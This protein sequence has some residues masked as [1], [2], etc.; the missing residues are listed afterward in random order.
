MS[1]CDDDRS[2]N[3][4]ANPHFQN[5]LQGYLT[6]RRVLQ[7]GLA[8]VTLSFL[9]LP[10]GGCGGDSD[11]DDDDDAVS[12]LGFQSISAS[13]DDTVRVPEGY[14]Y[15]V[16]APWGEPIGHISQAA[17]EP[18]YKDDASNTA[19]EQALQVG[20]HHDGMH[21]F[22][23]PA[24][25]D[26]SDHGLLVMNH[27]YVDDGLLQ[28]GGIDV[29]DAGFV[30]P[31]GW[32]AEKVAKAQNGHG[33]TILEIRR[34]GQQW[35]IVAPSQYARRITANTPIDI[36][37]PA[38]GSELMKTESDPAGTRVLGT[39]N[40]CAHGYTPWNTYLTCEENWNGY[41]ANPTGDVVGV[42]DGDQKLNILS[43]QSRYGI[44]QTGFGYRWH[45]FDERFDASRHPNEP[46]RF[47]W[48][49]EIDPFDP[50]STPVKHTAMGRIKHENA[51]YLVA[52]DNR[53]AFYMGD[54]E[55]NEYIYK[56]VAQNPYTPGNAAANRGLLDQGTLYVAKFN[57]DGTGQ[58][59]ALEHGQ[60]GL[61][62]E[63]GF[64][65]QAEVLI[66]TRQ[67][68]DRAGATMMDRPEWIAAHPTTGEVYATLTN[69]SRRGGD[70]ASG[71]NPDG[72]TSA[73]A[74]RPPVDAANPRSSNIHGHIIRWRENNGDPT[75]AGFT[76]D[77]FV[78]AGDPASSKET[79]K[80]N[81]NGDIFSAPDG[82]WIDP[83]GR[84][85]IQ[86]DVSTGSLYNPTLAPDNTDYQNFG[87]N[88]MLAADP[89]TGEI[90]RFL[91]GPIGCEVTGV[92][93]TPDQRTMFI[94]IQHPGEP[95]GI[96]QDDNT[97][98]NVTRFST[99]PD[100]G[101][102]RSATVV[103]TKDDGGII[104]T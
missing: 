4:G 46:N 100:G 42:P 85:W 80:G 57:E 77:I 89:T 66:K 45:E 61:T 52:A 97:A 101:R 38:A 58:W 75:G 18:A 37:G 34:D 81:I 93:T 17:G 43:G 47:G 26:S 30:S 50:S 21:F 15:Q 70:P 40:N 84:V 13:T 28:F 104:G 2:S 94:N 51:A 92:I 27:E 29:P 48:V 31:T 69:N 44:T 68:A 62:P 86:T 102:P 33:V 20:S 53:V 59:L 63:N 82:L 76:W 83:D 67:A 16:F 78:L 36:T 39:A 1:K 98:D 103:I 35:R 72:S 23:L 90:R 91:T 24:G 87:N 99:W 55:R 73:G 8:T 10:L 71:N 12:L 14:S 32:T 95:I 65:D 25:S 96:N 74:A 88:Q 54:D 64:A 19:A 11:D 41:F 3:P 5:V 9:G 7:G 60:N 79:S 22:P 56:F 6:R 49:V